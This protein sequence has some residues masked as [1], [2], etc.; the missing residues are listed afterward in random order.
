MTAASSAPTTSPTSTAAS[1]PTIEL[2]RSI[3]PTSASS[4]PPP[5]TTGW[6]IDFGSMQLDE[7]CLYEM[8]FEFVRAHVKPVRDL[9][10]DPALKQRW[11]LLK[12]P[13][14]GLRK[15]L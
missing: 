4:T 10:R 5:S 15:A 2:S 11:R 6:L 7:A 3:M 1:S 8:P 9:S 12:R 14:P 13:V